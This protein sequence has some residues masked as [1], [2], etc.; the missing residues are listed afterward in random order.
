MIREGQIH[1]G[2]DEK[3]RRNLTET[4]YRGFEINGMC[5]IYLKAH[6]IIF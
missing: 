5:H 2:T 1:K 6:A 3:C 4:I